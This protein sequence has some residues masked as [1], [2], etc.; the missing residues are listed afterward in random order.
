MKSAGYF[1]ASIVT[2]DSAGWMRWL[3]RSNSWTPS[4]SITISP[5]STTWSAAIFSTSFTTSGK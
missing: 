3:S 2:R 4:T 5:S 1:S